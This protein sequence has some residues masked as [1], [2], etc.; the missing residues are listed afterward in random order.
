MFPPWA[1]ATYRAASASAIRSS[2]TDDGTGQAL[3][4][5][6]EALINDRAMQQIEATGLIAMLGRRNANAVRCAGLTAV[7][8]QSTSLIR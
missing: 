6:V 2:A 7:A 8:T 1:F 3:Q 5:P 4:P